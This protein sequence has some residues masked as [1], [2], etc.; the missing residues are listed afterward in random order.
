MW[1]PWSHINPGPGNAG[2]CILESLILKISQ[3][4]IPLDSPRSLY[5][6]HS[7]F[8]TWALKSQCLFNLWIR[9]FKMLLP[10]IFRRPWLSHKHR[11]S[12]TSCCSF[13][14]GTI[15]SNLAL[16]ISNFCFLGK[17]SWHDFLAP[18]NSHTS[19]MKWIFSKNP[20][21]LWKFQFLPFEAIE[22]DI[23]PCHR[24]K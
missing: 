23:F 1:L 12:Q 20:H 15:S 8:A 17:L 9:Y 2:N 13:P 21:L 22:K 19:T 18:E 5:L 4:S 10:T 11:M 7:T 14:L 24:Y 6:R 3:G 16:T